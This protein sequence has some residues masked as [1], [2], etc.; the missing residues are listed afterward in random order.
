MTI[1]QPSNE[2]FQMFDRL[3]LMLDGKIVYQGQASDATDYFETHFGLKC[4]EYQNPAEFLIEA[5]HQEKKENI[6]RKE[7]Y[8]E[9]YDTNM[10]PLVEF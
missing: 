8:H 6:E 2:I 7:L 10:A 4:L 9:T 1:H 3:M 5:V